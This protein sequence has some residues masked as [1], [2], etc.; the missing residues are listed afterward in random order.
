MGETGNSAMVS[1]SMTQDRI[2]NSSIAAVASGKR[3]AKLWPLRLIAAAP[4]RSGV[5]NRFPRAL[6]ERALVRSEIASPRVRHDNSNLF[7][8]FEALPFSRQFGNCYDNALATSVATR[9]CTGTDFGRNSGTEIVARKT[10]LP[11]S[12]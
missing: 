9:N 3:S 11:S 10:T 5:P 7:A 4:R 8:A 12:A 1:P 6:A 2:D